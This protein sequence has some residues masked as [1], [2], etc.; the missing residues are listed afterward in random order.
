MLAPWRG[1]LLAPPSYPHSGW[2]VSA[3]CFSSLRKPN[4]KQWKRRSARKRG[5]AAAA[6]AAVAAAVIVIMIV[7]GEAGG[8]AVEVGS[9]AGGGTAVVVATGDGE[10]GIEPSL[11]AP[12][13]PGAAGVGIAVGSRDGGNTA[14][15][16]VEIVSVKAYDQ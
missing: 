2:M 3:Q 7:I 1:A 8:G 6:A 4:E 11:V 15:A 16:G 13:R 5:G 10:T 12:S 9:G 14:G